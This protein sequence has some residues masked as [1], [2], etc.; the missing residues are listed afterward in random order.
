MVILYLYN[1]IIILYTMQNIILRND[2]QE[3]ENVHIN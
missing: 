1:I 3:A 2:S